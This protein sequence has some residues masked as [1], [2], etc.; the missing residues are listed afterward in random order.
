MKNICK[1]LAFILITSSTVLLFLSSCSPT[2]TPAVP[3]QVISEATAEIFLTPTIELNTSPIDTWQTFSNDKYSF[4]YPRNAKLQ[5]G[6]TD[7]R[8]RFVFFGTNQV[9]PEKPQTTMTD[10]FLFEVYEE[11]NKDKSTVKNLTD[12]MKSLVP[13][14]CREG[15]TLSDSKDITVNKTPGLQFTVSD[16]MPS[17]TANDETTT[18]IFAR[19]DSA[20][21]ITQSQTGTSKEI[22]EYK[23]TTDKMLAS[24]VFKE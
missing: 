3:T 14:A 8:I 4:K 6:S 21:S 22:A 5:E 23:T 17:D 7:T 10:G 18:S 24:F 9:D 15:Y 20:L 1:N 12:T 13:T 2:T 16:C 19:K 11:Q